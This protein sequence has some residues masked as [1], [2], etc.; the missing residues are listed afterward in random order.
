MKAC[1]PGRFTLRPPKIFH[2]P[3][4]WA[5]DIGQASDREVRVIYSV[6]MVW[7]KPFYLAHLSRPLGC[8]LGHL[9]LTLCAMLSMAATAR[10]ASN[11]PPGRRTAPAFAPAPLLK[12]RSSAF[13]GLC[14]RSSRRGAAGVVMKK[15]PKVVVEDGGEAASEFGTKKL[16]KLTNIVRQKRGGDARG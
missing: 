7:T 8:A 12:A 5:P 15:P 4:L 2:L 9:L 14:G 3:L 13:S 16:G 11:E 6:A 10:A 1:E